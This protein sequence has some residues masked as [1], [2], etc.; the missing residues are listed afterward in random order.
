M[1]RTV[2]SGVAVETVIMP[3]RP[4]LP[5]R[6]L[7]VK[8]NPVT[9]AKDQHQLTGRKNIF[10]CVP[11]V[12]LVIFCDGVQRLA[13]KDV[14]GSPNF[15]PISGFARRRVGRRVPFIYK[16][17]DGEIGPATDADS[18]LIARQEKCVVNFVALS[19]GIKRIA[20]R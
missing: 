7:L 13:I 12:A 18:F 15:F 11:K 10:G 20:F 1:L 6:M 17:V 3:H 19:V 16:A 5:V 9:A 8:A 4:H 14:V 2:P